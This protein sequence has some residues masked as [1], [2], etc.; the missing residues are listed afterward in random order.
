MK[1]ILLLLLLAATLYASESQL[2]HV[3]LCWMDSTVTETEIDHLI[4][5]T[6]TLQEI[7]GILSLSVGRPVPSERPIVDDSFS[8]GIT[9][10]FESK[11]KMNAYL[12][13]EK[14]TSFVSQKVKPRLA[15]L[16][17]YDIQESGSQK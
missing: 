5:E 16:L 3:V 11:E 2:T 17:V 14:H 15:K 10:V 4:E 1:R 6:R 13:H 9:M 7:P 8:F 12:A